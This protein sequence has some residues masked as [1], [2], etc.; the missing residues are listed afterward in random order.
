MEPNGHIYTGREFMASQRVMCV[1]R[2]ALHPWDASAA[3]A[4]NQRRSVCMRAY[5]LDPQ[6]RSSSRS[7][8]CLR[9]P[10][11]E[12]EVQGMMHD[13]RTVGEEDA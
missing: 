1:S 7:R 12:P 10:L 5:S 3:I 13:H 4:Y 2:L 8:R 9:C 11:S 6:I